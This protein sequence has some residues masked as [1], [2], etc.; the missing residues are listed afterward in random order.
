[1]CA[2]ART[3]RCRIRPP[4]LAIWQFHATSRNRRWCSWLRL[5]PSTR[6]S[7]SSIRPW[8]RAWRGRDSWGRWHSSHIIAAAEETNSLLELNLY[9]HT[10]ENSA[11]RNAPAI[12][13]PKHQSVDGAFGLEFLKFINQLF[14]SHTQRLAHPAFR[15]GGCVPGRHGLARGSD[16]RGIG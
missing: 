11:H 1:M 3:S 5:C 13:R 14:Y 9:V 10:H 2:W 12:G 15:T 4:A 7:C 6:T 8:G 16:W